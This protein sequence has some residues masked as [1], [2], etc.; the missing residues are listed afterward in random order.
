MGN[1][2]RKN[3]E[4]VVIKIQTIS[5]KIKSKYDINLTD[6]NVLNILKYYNINDKITDKKLTE[7]IDDSYKILEYKQKIHR[8]LKDNNL[9][10][11][12]V[13]FNK[14]Y[15]AFNST[16]N[17]E[18]ALYRAYLY[19]KYLPEKLKNLDCTTSKINFKNLFINKLFILEK[20]NDKYSDNDLCKILSKHTENEIVEILKLNEN[21]EN[22]ENDN[23]DLN[24]ENNKEKKKKE[25]SDKEHD[26]DEEEPLKKC[27]PRNSKKNPAY[28]RDELIKILKDNMKELNLKSGQIS[29]MTKIDMCKYLKKVNINIEIDEKKKDKVD[30]EI[31]NL[32]NGKK[33]KK[34]KKE[35]KDE[36][37]KDKDK[38]EEN[39]EEDKDENKKEEKYEK[40]E[41]DEDDQDEDYDE[42]MKR[43]REAIKKKEEEIKKKEEEI[44]KKII[45]KKEEEIK[46]KEGKEIE[47]KEEKKK[48]QE[49]EEE[50]ED[51]EKKKKPINVKLDEIDKKII[52]TCYIPLNKDVTLKDY[53]I[54]V[55]QHMLKHRGLLA[56]HG[57]GTGKTLTAVASMNCI[58]R[59]YP[60]MNVIIITPT[61]LISNF[62]KEIK[63]FGIDIEKKPY[64]NRINFYS[65][66]QFVLDIHNNKHDFQICK[67]NF[68]IIDEAH[69]LRN[70]KNVKEHSSNIN[71]K[72]A[73]TRSG[74]SAATI[75]QCVKSAS[76]ILLLTATP[77]Q[78]R[79][80]D[81][82]SLIAM[83]DGTDIVPTPKD[84]TLKNIEHKFKCKISINPGNKTNN[85]YPIRIDVPIEET[86][87]IMDQDYY[88][89]YLNYQLVTEEAFE[90]YGV[91]S[92]VFYNAV[93][94]AAL[95]LDDINS[96]KVVWT[97]SKIMDEY[98]HNRKS[99]IYTSW[100][101]SGVFVVRQLLDANKIP[102]AMI[103]GDLSVKQRDEQRDAFN[104]DKV[105]ILII[106]R[107]GG[108]GLDLKGTNNIILMEPNWNKETDEQIIGRG[109][110]YKSHSHLPE[111]LRYTKVYKLYMYKPEKKHSIDKLPGADEILY[112][113]SY[114]IKDIEISEFMRLLERYSI[115]NNNCDCCPIQKRTDQPSISDEYFFD[116]YKMY[117]S[118]KKKEAK[119][120]VVYKPRL[121]DTTYL[122]GASN[123]PTKS[124]SN[125][126]KESKPEETTKSK[127][128]SK[129]KSRK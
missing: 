35:N 9:K 127:L 54:R 100:K 121:S 5:S 49:E 18:Y 116:I 70:L 106:T 104:N 42:D 39:N 11:N 15:E 67:D 19:K 124:R 96:P 22:E 107:A 91:I 59:N 58:M 85:D 12:D 72:S 10:I 88:M 102:Y 27:G 40:Y 48:K 74:I 126:I 57:T 38:Y 4:L 55:A 128:L 101:E 13:S 31:D 17:E 71:A 53:Q 82:D 94:R 83:I 30:K 79:I 28:T 64:K 109:I 78:N 2:I 118:N 29:K 105:K 61:S 89:K 21:K 37:N 95:S 129:I 46:K 56:I 81:I 69:N 7:L 65:F 92:N 75:L 45:K 115:E 111:N 122:Y 20:G 73:K 76:K 84:Y 98:N 33:G 25:K 114:E 87:F 36:E 86:K 80:S 24:E 41:K 120:K 119:E 62:K 1:S 43:I 99:V 60:N 117:K 63:K 110:R 66:K 6:E 47:K 26:D 23:E 113:M 34:G 14:I 32:L 108:E 90:R 51:D 52:N 68:V 8:Y 125:S 97:F 77:M 16:K 123:K 50:E 93:R 112:K 103:T 3:I 44:K